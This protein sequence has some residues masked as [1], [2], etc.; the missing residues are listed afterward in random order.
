MSDIQSIAAASKSASFKKRNADFFNC[1]ATRREKK[2]L[3]NLDA[4]PVPAIPDKRLRQSEKPVLNKLENQWFEICRRSEAITHLRAQALR[5]EL[6]RGI[7]YKPD[8]TCWQAGHLTAY[9]VKG[10]HAFRGGFE[11]LKV[12]ARTFPD[13]TWILVWKK[14]G[15]WRQQIVLP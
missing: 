15:Q 8:L 10:Q 7:W 2:A 1:A 4:P 5:F 6:G 12:A 14:D 9:E 11:N 13:W 3:S